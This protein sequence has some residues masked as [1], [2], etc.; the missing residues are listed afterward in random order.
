M[1]KLDLI[2]S[3]AQI[4]NRKSEDVA[5]VINTFIEGATKALATGQKLCI[6]NFGQFHVVIRA[7]IPHARN[8]KTGQITPVP[9]RAAVKFCAGKEL[10][11]R[12]EKLLT[13]S[14]QPIRNGEGKL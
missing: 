8:P 1:R 6:Q 10:R 11:E 2:K 9:K 7:A 5:Q 4:T 14:V 13:Q 3:T 12:V